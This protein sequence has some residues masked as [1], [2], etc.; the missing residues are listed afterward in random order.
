MRRVLVLGTLLTSAVALASPTVTVREFRGPQAARVRAGVASALS[1]R[2]HV[3]RSAAEADGVIEGVVARKGKRWRITVTIR[4]ARTGHWVD[5]VVLTV[6]RPALGGTAR[7][8]VARKVAMLLERNTD[9]G[10]TALA[11]A[12]E[13]PS[14]TAVATLTPAVA[15][16]TPPPAP[17]PLPLAAS[18]RPVD[19]TAAPSAARDAHAATVPPLG[20]D[21]LA[22]AAGEPLRRAGGRVLTV[23]AGTSFQ[24]RSFSAS[25]DGRLPVYK[26]SMYPSVYVGGTLYPLAIATR[27]ALAELGLFGSYELAV[28]L[29]SRAAQADPT[30]AS[31]DTHAE[32]AEVGVLY[33]AHVGGPAGV[34]VRPMFLYGQQQFDISGMTD[35]P[36]TDYQYY[37]FGL[38]V[39][40]PLLTPMVALVG[41]YQY[42]AIYQLGPAMQLGGAASASGMSFEAGLRASLGWH[43]QGI[44]CFGQT[45][46]DVSYAGGGQGGTNVRSIRDQWTGGR[47][48]LGVDF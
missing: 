6:R 40:V 14:A 48:A 3:T 11:S 19:E 31:F 26:S 10:V 13:A 39:D 38:D 9:D 41:A 32:R 12:Q 44:L 29:R 1:T 17:Q 47:V 22:M 8:H 4:N 20:D 15:R 25:G 46:R 7:K 34:T 27:G 2:L 23:S 24:S 28:G 35:M 21:A 36:D 45:L 43:V 37:G 18:T 5:D 33:R 42:D 30:G 16:T